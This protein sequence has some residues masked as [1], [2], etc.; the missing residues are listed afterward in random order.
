[1]LNTDTA[2]VETRI[3]AYKAAARTAGVKLTP[4]RLEIFSHIASSLE[5][6]DA[7]AVFNAVRKRMPT[8]S[9][10]TVYRTLWLLR[11]MGLIS[12]LGPR[13]D[14][15]RF[16][17]NLDP[18]HHFVCERCGLARDFTSPA[19]DSLEVPKPA[20]GFGKVISTHIELRGICRSCM[21]KTVKE[22]VNKKT[23]EIPGKGRREVWRKR[24]KS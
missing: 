15:V 23:G 18:H 4:Q 12:T 19:Y 22:S 10:D 6:P 17:A 3:H 21:G 1:M 5:H 11:D 16:D 9:R 8:V 7:E 2:A 13:R 20:Q 14:S 24:K